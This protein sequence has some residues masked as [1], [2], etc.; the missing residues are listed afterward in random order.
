MII[1]ADVQ[2]SMR[3]MSITCFNCL[4]NFEASDAEALCQ[5]IVP[6]QP[7]CYIVFEIVAS[8]L[9]EASDGRVHSLLAFK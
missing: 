5:L 7:L 9:D 8:G 4:K 1:F 3:A 2:Y 6:Q